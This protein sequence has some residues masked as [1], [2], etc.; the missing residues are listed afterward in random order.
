MSSES[1]LNPPVTLF[2]FLFFFLRQAAIEPLELIIN[3][4][5][6][7]LD[8]T[9]LRGDDIADNNTQLADLVQRLSSSVQTLEAEQEHRNQLAKTLAEVMDASRFLS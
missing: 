7:K 2:V 8:V 1:N 3:D 9:G 5:T 6:Y 4:K